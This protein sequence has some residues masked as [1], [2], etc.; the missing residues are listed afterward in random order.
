MI[1]LAITAIADKRVV[2]KQKT[3]RPEDY[4]EEM[5]IKVVP[6]IVYTFGSVKNVRCLEQPVF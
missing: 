5:L 2:N 1:D 6:I 3:H 4:K